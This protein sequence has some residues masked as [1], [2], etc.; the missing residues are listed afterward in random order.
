[1]PIERLALAQMP[2]LLSGQGLTCA[3]GQGG[4]SFQ[5]S[6]SSDFLHDQEHQAMPQMPNHIP[7]VTHAVCLDSRLSPHFRGGPEVF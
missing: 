5:P 3:R 1:M 6:V 7:R 4:H 2:F